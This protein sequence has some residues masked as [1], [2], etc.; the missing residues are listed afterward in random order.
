MFWCN[1][2]KNSVTVALG[3]IGAKSS[4][5]YYSENYYC[6]RY[7]YDC[8]YHFECNI[9]TGGEDPII[10]TYDFDDDG[11]D[12]IFDTFY[13]DDFK[14]GMDYVHGNA[15]YTNLIRVILPDASETGSQVAI[16]EITA[17]DSDGNPVFPIKH[18]HTWDDIWLT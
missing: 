5:D 8:S 15:P 17:Y 1:Q 4:A 7:D 10:C 2:K 3:N 18:G 12:S 11:L 9:R 13:Y 16:F 14:N 6:L